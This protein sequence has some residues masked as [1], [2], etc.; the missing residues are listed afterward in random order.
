MTTV[1]Y[2]ALFGD[3]DLLWPPFPIRMG[4]VQFV[5][6]SDRPRKEV[7]LWTRG[8]T[9][10]GPHL[11]EGSGNLGSPYG[12]LWEVRIVE[13]SAEPRKMARYCKIMSHEVLPDAD[14]TIWLDANVRLL[15]SPKE[16]IRKWLGSADLATCNHPYRDCL[17]LE[18]DQ[19]VRIG[20]ASPKSMQ[21]QTQNYREAGMP[22]N[23]GLASTRCVIR[24][25]TFRTRKLNE[26]WWHEVRTQSL[27]DQVSLPYICWRA[28]FR[29]KVIPGAVDRRTMSGRNKDFLFVRH[30]TV[31]KGQPCY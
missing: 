4:D 31:S 5:C 8:G 9:E 27:R 20:K 7:G 23:W 28:G 11:L 16:A 6:F 26:M 30:L 1:V 29:W 18:A 22:P 17:Y 21:A 12:A 14:V 10:A 13:M 19:C 24:R 2:T 3:I 15:I 25:N